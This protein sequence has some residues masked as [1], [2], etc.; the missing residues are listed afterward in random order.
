MK[1]KWKVFFMTNKPILPGRCEVCK[2][3]AMCEAD[4]CDTD[5]ILRW[6]KKTRERD[7]CPGEYK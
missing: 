4:W 2:E 1:H 3:I 7:D 5:E 6:E